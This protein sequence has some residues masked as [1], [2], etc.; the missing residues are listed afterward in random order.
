MKSINSLKIFIV[1]FTIGNML[2]ISCQRNSSLPLHQLQVIETASN[3]SKLQLLENFEGEGDEVEI[4]LFP[5]Q[6]YQ[7]ILGLGGS[8][9]EASAYNFFQLSE[10]KRKELI[11]AYFG[12][13]GAR[14]TLA[15]TTINSCD[16]S[17]DNYAYAMSP[18]DLKLEQFTINHDQALIIPFIKLALAESENGI[19][20]IASPWTAPPWMKDNHS[21]K[22]G[23]L[24]PEF[25][26]TWALYFSKYI[27]AYQNSGIKIW[28]ITVENEPLGN[29]NNWESMH[30]TPFEMNNFVKYHLKPHFDSVQLET[31]I[32]GY[33]QNR[34]EEIKEW[35]NAM[36]DH[37]EIAS[38]YDGMAVHWYG[39]TESYFPEMLNYVHQKNTSKYII[40]TEACIDAE[41]PRWKNDEWYWSKEAK[42][43][44]FTWA[45]ENKK[46]LHP[47]Y[48]PTFR[49]ARDII[50][51]LNNHVNA[52]IDWN[53][54]LDKEGGPN[55]AK[56]WCIAPVIV[57]PEKD[58]IYYTPLYYVMSHFSRYIRPNAKRIGINLSNQQLEG[59]AVKNENGEIVVVV[60][61]TSKQPKN[62]KL[63]LE[64]KSILIPIKAE[65]IQTIILNQQK[66]KTT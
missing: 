16:F 50:G 48:V 21:W 47:K 24:L 25:Y 28:G 65:A 33:D 30:F 35:A 57:D 61:N 45:P 4:N 66:G 18:N 59:T 11:K 41:K 42:D 14:Y 38:C 20:I 53:L 36:Y 46:H 9:T 40:Q 43:W 34:D 17:L 63:G 27:Q 5:N 6:E 60:I 22:G 56:N 19:D 51:C 8:F 32:L 29:D 13:D 1:W 58:E 62:I 26:P 3:G 23:K 12:K 44:G 31:K 15:R 39:S 55:W 64:G 37:E 49:Y 52:W 10:P 2:Q 7:T 54:I